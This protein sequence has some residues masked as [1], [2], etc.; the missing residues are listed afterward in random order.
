MEVPLLYD[1]H[2]DSGS[3]YYTHLNMLTNQMQWCFVS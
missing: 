3:P 1:I 2:C